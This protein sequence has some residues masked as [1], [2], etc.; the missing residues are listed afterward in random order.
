MEISALRLGLDSQGG[1]PWAWKPQQAAKDES[2]CEVPRSTGLLAAAGG[3]HFPR[4]PLF[5]ALSCVELSFP[6]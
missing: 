1:Q 3:A 4:P 6:V 2:S 5:E